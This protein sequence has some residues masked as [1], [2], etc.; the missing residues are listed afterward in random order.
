M[1]GW[2]T[3]CQRDYSLGGTIPFSVVQSTR[4]PTWSCPKLDNTCDRFVGVCL[5]VNNKVCNCEHV[6]SLY[7][8]VKCSSIL[9]HVCVKNRGTVHSLSSKKRRWETSLIARQTAFFQSTCQWRSFAKLHF[10][11]LER[12]LCVWMKGWTL[13]SAI[14]L[15]PLIILHP[16]TCLSFL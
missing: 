3:S 1:V 4:C 16:K 12:C 10:S 13:F 2:L 6:K 11:D 14:P 8:T 7:S 5:C 15:S 9:S